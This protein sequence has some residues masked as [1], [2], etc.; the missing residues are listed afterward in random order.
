MAEVEVGV[1]RRA[2]GSARYAYEGG[3]SALAAVYAP[4]SGEGRPAAGGRSA[5]AGERAGVEVSVRAGA[6][7][8]PRAPL[9]AL[10][11]MCAGAL[12]AVLVRE[13]YPRCSIGVHVQ[14]E[15]DAGSVES[16]AINAAA[17]ACVDAGLQMTGMLAAC[18][19]AVDRGGRVHAEPG[20]REIA[21]AEAAVHLAFVSRAI[22][23]GGADADAHDVV[24]CEAVGLL[25]P[26]SLEAC[27]RLGR[28]LVRRT[29]SAVRRGFDAQM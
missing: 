7:G 11:A 23:G 9:R 18:S 21:G 26:E 29:V 14:V 22:D 8:G 28:K 12:E 4:R 1:L 24:A 15:R 2:D 25:A 17:A 16:C 20:H 6:G 27:V 13:A 19:F 10:E 3:S 5:D